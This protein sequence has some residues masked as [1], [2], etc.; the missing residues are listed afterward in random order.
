LTGNDQSTRGGKNLFQ[1]LFVHHKCHLDS[2]GIE[3]EPPRWEASN[4]APEPRH[5]LV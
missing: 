1:C 3:P 4:Q 5:G 2:L